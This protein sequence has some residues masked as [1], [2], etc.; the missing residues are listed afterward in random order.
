VQAQL[1]PS[2]HLYSRRPWRARPR[3]RRWLSPDSASSVACYDDCS[4]STLHRSPRPRPR[5][6]HHSARHSGLS[7]PVEPL[8]AAEVAR[9]DAAAQARRERW[10]RRRCGLDP[11][12]SRF[13]TGTDS[14]PE[15]LTNGTELHLA[16]LRFVDT[17]LKLQGADHPAFAALKSEFADVLGGPPPGLPPDRGI[18]LVLETG[19]HPMPRTRPTKR[20][21]EGELTELRRQLLDLLDCGWIQPSMADHAASVVFARKPDGSWR[22]C[23]DY[24]GLNAITEP[25]VEPRPHIDETKGV[26][27][28]TKFDL[29]QGYHQVRV[30][31][32]DWWETSFRSR[33]DSSNGES[34]RSGCKGRRQSSCGS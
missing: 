12:L 18:E 24:R 2:R 10:K 1:N 14:T 5:P 33:L 25:L 21:S 6:C 22:I 29:A 30:R 19:D 27:W 17:S 3:P 8:G 26:R 15:R 7:K 28:F 34:C 9:L 4:R 31:E 20:L 11:A 13:T 16:S 23:Y 32:A